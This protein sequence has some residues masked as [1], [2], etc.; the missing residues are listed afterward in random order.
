MKELSFDK[1]GNLN[2]GAYCDLIR[3][4]YAGGSGYQGPS[5]VLAFAMYNYCS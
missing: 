3:F 4:W 5:E 2:G 1:M